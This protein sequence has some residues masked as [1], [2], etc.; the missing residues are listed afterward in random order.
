[1]AVVVAALGATL[2][3]LYAQDAEDR[4]AEKYQS[5]KVLVATQ[6][7]NPGESAS[8]AFNSGKILSRDVPQNELLEGSTNDGAVF[9]DQV[10]LTT[11]YPGEQLVTQ[12]FGGVGDIEAAATLPLP[13]GMVGKAIVL[14]DSSRIS[15]F[16][17]PGTRVGMLITG[18]FPPAAQAE[19]RLLLGNVSILA[20]GTVTLGQVTNPDG[21]TTTGTTTDGAPLSQYVL[22]LKPKDAARIDLA[23]TLGKISLVLLP[24]DSDLRIGDP[25]TAENLFS[26]N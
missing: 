12:K 6:Q 2:V 8:D 13:D 26:G 7:I 14:D 20:T 9:V 1:M 18:T 19:T 23:Q 3:F 22:A 21:T 5:V 15:G 4:A 25:I 10:A 16:T 11:L 17:R 24:A